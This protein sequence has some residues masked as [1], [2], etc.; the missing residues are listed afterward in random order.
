VFDHR[1]ERPL[2]PFGNPIGFVPASRGGVYIKSKILRKEILGP[3]TMN[4]IEND[5][6]RLVAEVEELRAEQ[7]QLRGK[8]ESLKEEYSA[9]I[10]E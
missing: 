2:L 4:L 1:E 8:I 6:P 3:V 5:V 7:E 10:T 9:L